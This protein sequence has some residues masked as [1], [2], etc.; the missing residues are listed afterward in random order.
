MKDLGKRKFSWIATKQKFK[1]DIGT[2]TML[3]LIGVKEIQNGQCTSIKHTHNCKKSKKFY[4]W[5][6]TENEDNLGPKVPRISARLALEY[7]T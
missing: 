5:P 1:W 2:S 3:H 4:K 7:L 6:I